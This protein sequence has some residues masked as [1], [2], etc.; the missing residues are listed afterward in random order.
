MA[1]K[2]LPED[3]A[4]DALSLEAERRRK[5]LGRP[6]SYG[7]LVA[8]TTLAQRQEIAEAYRKSKSYKKTGAAAKYIPVNPGEDLTRIRERARKEHIETE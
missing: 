8:D 1:S 2:K 7:Q 5:L 6:C 4:I 3:Y